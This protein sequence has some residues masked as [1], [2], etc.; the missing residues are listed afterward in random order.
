MKQTSYIELCAEDL[1]KLSDWVKAR[2]LVDDV[3]ELKIVDGFCSRV[4]LYVSDQVYD[5]HY[6]NIVG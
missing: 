5:E 3:V 6:R 1:N 4:T 2:T